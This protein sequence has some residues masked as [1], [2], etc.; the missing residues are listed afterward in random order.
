MN[1]T[2]KQISLFRTLSI[3]TGIFTMVIAFTMIMSLIQLKSSDPLSSPALAA[4]YEQFDRDPDNAANAEYVRSLDLVARKA[5]FTARWQLETGSY[6]LVIGAALFVL[7]RWL[8][9]SNEPLIKSKLP[10]KPVLTETR[11]R[12]RRYLVIS[13][14]AVVLLAVISSFI[15]RPLMPDPGR[16]RS[17]KVSATG[18]AGEIPMPDEIN[19]PFFRGAGGR[20]IAAGEGYPVEWN[21][22][23]G[24]NIRWK[25]P[26]PKH[27]KS[28]PVIWGDKIFLTGADGSALEVYCIDKNT[29]NILWTGS[30][31]DFPGA[32][33]ETPESDQE[34]GMA[35]STAAATEGAV[36]AIFG[37]GNL[38]AYDHTGKL[39]WGTNLGV[40][41]HMYGYSSSLLIW[42]DLV[43]IQYDSDTRL[44]VIGIDLKSGKIR[45]ETP[46]RGRAVNS[47]PVLASFEGIP[48]VIINGSPEVTA[49]EAST[50]KEVWTM[51]GVKNDVA[52]SPGY[53]KNYVYICANY[54]KLI[55]IKAGK[56]PAVA[57]EDNTY[58]PD[59]S[60]PAAT[61]EFLFISDGTGGVACYD[62]GSN[63]VLWENYFS[64]PFYASP[65][66]ADG[67][68]YFLD[69][70]GVMHIVKA[71]GTY[72]LISQPELGEDADCTPAFSEKRIYIRGVNNLYCISND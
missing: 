23:S 51:P 9:Y 37:N 16:T 39:L 41:E 44:A 4:V 65:M 48:Q 63:K 11:E 38:V 68:V 10:P 29:G 47:S 32:S 1:L 20:G 70:K 3:I 19:F 24:E 30:G 58:T 72:E 5:Y 59:V 8:T 21:G 12:N 43:I 53:N 15:L 17:E 40:P 28:S 45:W 49:F 33:K 55:A 26:V 61:D 42:K 18:S 13:A 36:C 46:R 14:A 34:A 56:N 25:I 69:R 54:E 7:F 35:V 62:A 67:K 2:E 22:N 71:A 66:V 31:S 60:S 50:G 64:E 27:G 6:L 52:V 57:W